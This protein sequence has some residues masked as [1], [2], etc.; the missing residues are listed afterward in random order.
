MST[1]PSPSAH[2]PIVT[3]AQ[4]RAQRL[5]LLAHEKELTKAYDRVNAERRHLP[6]VRIDKSYVFAG[7]AGPVTLGDCF[8]GR[9]QLI[10]YHFMFDP[11]WEK[12]CK[13]CTG[14]V[15]ALGD[16][17]LLASRDTTFVVISRAP[18]PKLQ[19]YRAE[20]GWDIAWLSS[21]G[22]DFNYDFHATL[23]PEKAPVEY[24][25]RT[26]AET[27]AAEGKA[28]H[29]EGEAHALSVFFRLG[30]DVFHT[31]SAFARGCEGLTD[32]YHLLDMTPYGRQQDFEDSPA[33]WPQRPTYG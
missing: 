32:A 28:V 4:W 18:L 12:G 22:S 21:F 25:Y 33:G 10:V 27:E 31:Y 24:N 26:K 15:D 16:L 11:G 1:A 6:M 19:A 23:D 2:P 7:P 17:S 20:K 3:R 13:G 9:R 30:P 14:F 8:A 29:M 5:E